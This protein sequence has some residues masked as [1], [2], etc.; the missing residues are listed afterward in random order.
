[1]PD[2]KILGL[3]L[4]FSLMLGQ[5]A[6]CQDD[7]S[8]FHQDQVISRAPFQ[9]AHGRPF[10]TSIDAGLVIGFSSVAGIYTNYV[11]GL[12]AKTGYTFGLIEEIP[13]QRR[14][15]LDVG[16]EILQSGLSFNSY[17]FSPDA[18][19][20]YNGVEPYTHS[21]TMNEIQV[22]VLFKFPLCPPDRKLRSIYMTVGVKFRYIS[23]TN[24][25]VTNDSTGFLTWEGNKDVASLY[26][27]FS[28]FGSSV[29]ELSI[30]YQRNAL[31]KKRRGWYMNLEYNYGLSPLVYSGNRAGSNEVVFRLNSLIFKVG[32]IF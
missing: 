7:P 19:T 23:F 32:K 18:S 10:K 12:S 21:I 8:D 29:A 26:S 24:S 25:T 16:I 14:S 4:I 11:N 20:I 9:E 6:I 31:K 15:Y 3:I 1:M 27:I 5:R 17:F 13:F 22:P 28:P 30:G 2:R